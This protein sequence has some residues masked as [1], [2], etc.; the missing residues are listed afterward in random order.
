MER[1][2]IDYL[3]NVYDKLKKDSV[4]EEYLLSHIEGTSIKDGI[5][6]DFLSGV[7]NSNAVDPLMGAAGD[8]PLAP[9]KKPKTL[10]EAAILAKELLKTNQEDTS[11]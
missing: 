2:Y 6:R 3:K 4:T 9:V 1:A 11:W 10:Q 7:N 5:I 8:I